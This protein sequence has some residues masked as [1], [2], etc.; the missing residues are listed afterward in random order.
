[1]A[2]FAAEEISISS[3]N[4]SKATEEFENLKTE[5]FKKCESLS[6][7]DKKKLDMFFDYM[8]LGLNE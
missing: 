2:F 1:M 7:A 8:K 6:A 5:T 4:K 3:E